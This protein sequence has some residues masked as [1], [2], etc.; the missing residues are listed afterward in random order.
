MEERHQE[1]EKGLKTQ[2]GELETENYQVRETN[3]RLEED[4][5]NIKEQMSK[6]QIRYD[7]QLK[8]YEEKIGELE[9]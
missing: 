1:Q 7:L 6:E 9:S 2:I 5:E 8:E 3:S 4:I